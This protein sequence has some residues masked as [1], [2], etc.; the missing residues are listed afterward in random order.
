MIFYLLALLLFSQFFPPA[1]VQGYGINAPSTV[2]VECYKP[3]IFSARDTMEKITAKKLHK[4]YKA[5]RK[6]DHRGGGSGVVLRRDGVILT[7]AHV[8]RGTSLMYVE[9]YEGTVYNAVVLARDSK[10]DLALLKIVPGVQ[11]PLKPVRLGQDRPRGWPVYA[12]GNPEF[13]RWIITTGVVGSEDDNQT[14]MDVVID[15]GSSGGGLFDGVTHRL[16]GVTV[17]IYHNYSAAVRAET[18]R[19]F[20]DKFMPLATAGTSS[21]RS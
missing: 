21:P 3:Y 20:V 9:T 6:F 19:A 1:Y 18:V 12:I 4:P 15:H 17:Q 5:P 7:A 16:L 10:A 8:V 14:I 2:R 13:L 11:A